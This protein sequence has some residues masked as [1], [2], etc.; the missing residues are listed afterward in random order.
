MQIIGADVE[1]L[2]DVENFC[3]K[4]KNG[5]DIM[6]GHYAYAPFVKHFIS[7]YPDEKDKSED[8]QKLRNAYLEYTRKAYEL[9]RNRTPDYANAQDDVTNWAYRYPTIKECGFEGVIP[10]ELDFNNLARIKRDCDDI[11]KVANNAQDILDG[12]EQELDNKGKITYKDELGELHQFFY[13]K[14]EKK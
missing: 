5:L 8:A 13:P 6:Q 14:A 2:K 10:V 7:Y 9:Q 3:Y 4:L 11:Y 1:I 12:R